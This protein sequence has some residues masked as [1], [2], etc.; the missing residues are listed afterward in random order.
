MSTTN[1]TDDKTQQRRGERK[2]Q[3]EA[4]RH[5]AKKAKINEAEVKAQRERDKYDVFRAK[6]M[7]CEHANSR[8][9][10][11]WYSTKYQP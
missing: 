1:S 10:N 5:R 7:K 6:M 11:Y 2:R 3:T 9:R 4:D 8:I